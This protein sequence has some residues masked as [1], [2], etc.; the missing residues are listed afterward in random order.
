[1]G[2]P[3]SLIQIFE[4]ILESEIK[5]KLLMEIDKESLK[6]NTGQAVISF[7]DR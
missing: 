7:E 2:Q 1:M 4:N 5:H 3:G 6:G